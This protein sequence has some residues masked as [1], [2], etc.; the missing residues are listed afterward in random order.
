[1]HIDLKNAK[2]TA[3]IRVKMTKR[4][5]LVRHYATIK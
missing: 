1:M 4:K 5:D 3:R 2:Y